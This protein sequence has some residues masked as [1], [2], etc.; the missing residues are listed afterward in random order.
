MSA[1]GSVVN[2]VP[3]VVV[4]PPTRM[5][6][7]PQQLGLFVL[8]VHPAE[9]RVWLLFII[10][11]SWLGVLTTGFGSDNFIRATSYLLELKSWFSM[12]Y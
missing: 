5:R 7:A 4:H 6:L 3:V 10:L 9:V 2:T 1:V 12:L 11:V 8:P